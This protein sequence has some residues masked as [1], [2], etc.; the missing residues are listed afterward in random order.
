MKDEFTNRL[1]MFQTVRD[2]VFA[3][4]WR[5]VWEGK[6][7]LIFGTRA[8]EMRTA[9]A[10]L[11]DFCRRQGLNLLGVAQDKDREET[12][13]EDAAFVTAGLLAE[14]Y[15]DR[16]N[17]TEVAKFDRPISFWRQLRDNELLAEA[18][19]VVDAATAVAA[20]AE[21]TEAALYDLTPAAATALE[22]EWKDYAACVTAPV[23]AI[24][25][26]RALTLA[27]RPEFA[28]VSARFATLDKLI[29]RFDGTAEGRAFIATYRAAR[30]I[31]DAG[32][33]P[34]RPADGETP[35]PV[36]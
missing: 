21:A 28:R 14:F 35:P 15:R 16:D 10:D 30:I 19:T 29:L 8:E 36:E 20:G 4:E 22:K 13:L 32:R 11:E 5:A 23:G 24:S 9:V 1:G 3:E 27:L 6:P 17:L 26:R 25:A 2:T 34:D 7:P 33:R 18:R 31:R 12:E